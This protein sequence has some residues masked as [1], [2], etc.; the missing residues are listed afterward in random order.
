MHP[1]GSVSVAVYRPA[2]LFLSE[3][4]VGVVASAVFPLAGMIFVLNMVFTISVWI[5]KTI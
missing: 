4:V 5:L 1:S 2:V 3:A